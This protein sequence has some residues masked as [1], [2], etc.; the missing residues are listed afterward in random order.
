MTQGNRATGDTGEDLAVRFLEKHGCRI[1]CRNFKAQH[2][3]IDIIAEKD[4]FLLFVEVK[5]RRKGGER[6]ANAVDE[7]KQTRLA[8]AAAQFLAEN[9]ENPYVASLQ[10]RFDV[11]EITLDKKNRTAACRLLENA[12]TPDP[13]IFETQVSNRL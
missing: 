8:S 9:R 6:G 10:K 3:E 7:K 4:A 1:L 2:G 11:V 12:F 13:S 5:T